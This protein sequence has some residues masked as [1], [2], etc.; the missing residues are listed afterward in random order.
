MAVR[1]KDQRI[2]I[3]RNDRSENTLNPAVIVVK[4]DLLIP[5]WI[6][7]AAGSTYFTDINPGNRSRATALSF[8]L[9]YRNSCQC[10]DKLFSTMLN[11]FDRNIRFAVMS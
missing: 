7:R 3:R 2:R 1:F 8:S 9:F 4:R 10:L 5:R 6:I 11:F